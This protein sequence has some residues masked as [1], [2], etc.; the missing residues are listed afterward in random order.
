[1]PAF[2]DEHGRDEQ[3]PDFTRCAVSPVISRNARNPSI[4]QILAV[5]LLRSVDEVGPNESHAY[6]RLNLMGRDSDHVRMSRTR[7]A[8]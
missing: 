2:G 1:M 7:E 5:W 4:A 8:P 3:S 6:S